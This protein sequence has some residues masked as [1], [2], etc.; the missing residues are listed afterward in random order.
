[1]RRKIRA[2]LDLKKKNRKYNLKKK[3]S[4]VKMKVRTKGVFFS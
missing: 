4:C 3:L 2:D 1:M